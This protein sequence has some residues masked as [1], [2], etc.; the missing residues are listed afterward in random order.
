M[1]AMIETM[2]HNSSATNMISIQN[3]PDTGGFSYIECFPLVSIIT[4]TLNSA[5]L[6]KKTISSVI[7]QT[8]PNIEFIIIDGGSNDS[9][10]RYIKENKNHISYYK[11]E[12]DNG[13]Y[14]AMNKGIAQA[15]GQYLQFLNAGDYY[16]S[17][18]SLKKLI[19]VSNND[20]DILYGDILLKHE[21]RSLR[22][23]HKAMQFNLQNLKQFGTGVLCHQAMLVKRAIAVP[24]NCRYK[25]KAELNWYFDLIENDPPPTVF[26]LKKPFVVYSLGG[27]GYKNF[28]NNRLEWY[29]LLI[30]RFGPK[31]VFNHK[32]I[33]FILTDFSNRYHLL[34]KIKQYLT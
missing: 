7:E 9:T 18:A 17:E 26:H 22:R 12:K 15:K 32:F 24:Y 20:Y 5:N 14:D 3:S 16:C 19:E 30:Y 23:H 29:K 1:A 21:K 25:F 33:K 34:G 13:I 31:T 27:T 28:I 10:H 8:Y 2:T 11:S 4:V 6:L